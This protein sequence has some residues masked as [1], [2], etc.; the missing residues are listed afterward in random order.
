MVHMLKELQGFSKLREEKWM[1]YMWKLILRTVSREDR[2]N[3]RFELVMLIR[4]Q[5]L[6]V[7]C[8]SNILDGQ[9]E[10]VLTLVLIGWK[11]HKVKGYLQTMKFSCQ[12]FPHRRK[13]SQNLR[14]Q[15]YWSWN[16]ME[17]PTH[18]L[19]ILQYV[20]S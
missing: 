19:P 18:S 5:M 6:T 12:N 14:S 16:F 8:G 9:L 3:V 17:Q 13:E 15:K 10:V 11:K 1:V 2:N 7:G 20:S 4:A